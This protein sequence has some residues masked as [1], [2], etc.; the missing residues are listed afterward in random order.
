MVLREKRVKKRNKRMKD[1]RERSGVL[2]GDDKTDLATEERRAPGEEAPSLI[3]ETVA[4]ERGLSCAAVM[5]PSV[6]Q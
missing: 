6:S 1:R 4:A 2:D 3:T 5:R